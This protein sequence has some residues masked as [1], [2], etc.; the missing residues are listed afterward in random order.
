MAALLVAKHLKR[1]LILLEEGIFHS[2]ETLYEALSCCEMAR[3]QL[4]QSIH[5]KADYATALT[6]Q[7]QNHDPVKLND[8]DFIA[9]TLK[10]FKGR[11]QELL[12]ALSD[13]K[14]GGPVELSDLVPVK[15]PK[16]VLQVTGNGLSG[17]LVRIAPFLCLSEQCGLLSVSD[18]IRMLASSGLNDQFTSCFPK[19]S[20]GHPQLLHWKAPSLTASTMGLYLHSFQTSTRFQTNEDDHRVVTDIARTFADDLVAT[21]G[22]GGER[23]EQWVFVKNGLLLRRSQKLLSFRLIETSSED[24]GS[25]GLLFEIETDIGAFQIRQD[26]AYSSGHG[27]DTGSATLAALASDPLRYA[28]LLVADLPAEDEVDEDEFRGSNGIK[29]N[30]L[31]HGINDYMQESFWIPNFPSAYD[32]S[33][34]FHCHL[35]DGFFPPDFA[36]IS[37]VERKGAGESRWPAAQRG[38]VDFFQPGGP[39]SIALMG[40]SPVWSY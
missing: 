30:I 10:R 38:P 4:L 40:D 24:A 39:V 12:R 28:K 6:E 13:V 26:S 11:E 9:N 33:P 16:S 7:Y 8:P 21:W 2:N 36:Y 5:Q 34:Q 1:A 15:R 18:E 25:H 22:V 19:Y 27:Y 35:A 37:I 29:V 3:S 32:P 17:C 14:D 31:V 23:M 20:N